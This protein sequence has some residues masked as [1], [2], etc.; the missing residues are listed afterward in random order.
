V[1]GPD[2]AT[3]AGVNVIGFLDAETGVGE[4]ARGVLRS[5]EAVGYP[6]AALSIRAFDTSR[7]GDASAG[8]F[9]Q[10]APHRINVFHVNADMAEPVA[11]ELGQDLYHRRYNVGYWFWELSRFPERW[12]PAFDIYDEIWVGSSFVQTAVAE[13]APIPVVRMPVAVAPRVDER[14]S[15]RDLGLPEQAFV[16]LLVFDALSII[17]RKNPGAAIRAFQSAFGQARSGDARLVVKVTN[18][19]RFPDAA[20]ALRQDL[21]GVDGVLIDRY[22]D[23]GEVNA[24][25]RHC[26]AYLSLHRSEGLG[27]TL[28]EA[29]SMGK[30]VI[31]TAYSGNADFMTPDNSYPVPYR[32]IP[33]SRDHP[34]YPAG[35]EWAEPDVEAAAAA[36]RAVFQDPR[37]AR[38]RGALAA[39]AIRREHSHEAV[40][41]RLTA[42]LA[43]IE[44]RLAR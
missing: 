21:R 43:L 13:R 33:L 23:R 18:L 2:H 12:Q 38:R 6:A 42:R 44:E 34:P 14:V 35:Y 32:L 7:H 19:E 26:D 8:R 9:P 10:G 24:L 37:E 25:I 41:R 39:D 15:R 17:E 3:R 22:L 16:V 31:A 4:V 40:G 29:M 11:R 1:A 5:L 28:A 36:L 20:A 27:L 30:P